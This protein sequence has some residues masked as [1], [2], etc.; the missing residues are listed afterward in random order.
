LQYFASEDGKSKLRISKKKLGTCKEY[1]DKCVELCWMM[2][3]QDP[4]I[5]MDTNFP[6]NS[7]FDSNKMRSYTKAGKFVHFVV[8]PTFFLHKDG[9][10]LGKGVVQG[11]KKE[12]EV[13][14]KS[15]SE[16]KFSSD[17][18]EDENFH[19]ARSRTDSELTEDA[20]ANA[21]KPKQKE[22]DT[23]PEAHNSQSNSNKGNFKEPN[24]EKPSPEGPTPEEPNPEGPNPEGPNPEEPNPE[25]PNSDEPNGDKHSGRPDGLGRETTDSERDT[26]V[27]NNSEAADGMEKTKIED[28]HNGE[29]LNDNDDCGE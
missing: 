24:Q 29:V 14:K 26:R 10:L 18:S 7:E 8:W 6:T 16:S 9:P 5:H 27:W 3:I 19:D 2:R 11:S 28:E 22:G 23:T 1:I 13:I 21:Q 4:P 12:V 15:D 25:E 17:E 20:S